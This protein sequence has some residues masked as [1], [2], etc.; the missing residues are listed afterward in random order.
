MTDPNASAGGAALPAT[1]FFD[2]AFERIPAAA[3]WDGS[4]AGPVLLLFDPRA[5]R[6]WVADAAI[7]LATAWT[8]AGRRAVLA[9]LSLD[10]PLLHERIGMANLDGVVDIFL[11]GAS[12]ARSARPVPGRGFYLISG[13]TYTDDPGDILRHP[14]WEKIVSGFREAQA[15]LL[16]FAPAGA[17]GLDALA[18][19][20][21]D[22]ILFGAPTSG[23]AFLAA[24]PAGVAP[25][26][27]LAPPAADPSLHVE[28]HREPVAGHGAAFEDRF[29]EPEPAPT[30]WP[31]TP[32]GAPTP[33]PKA[34][35]HEGFPTFDELMSTPPEA[36]PVP[37][38]AWETATMPSRFG[39]RRRKKKDAE[40]SADAPSSG[41]PS[42][43]P[44]PSQKRLVVLLLLLLVIAA[45]YF[46]WTYHPEML[47]IGGAATAAVA[48]VAAAAKPP[49]AVAERGT[50]LPY[51]VSTVNF[52]SMAPARNAVR[53][54]SAKFPEV[55]FYVVPETNQGRLFYKVLAGL[56]P[57][58]TQAVAVRNRL[59][60]AG[61]ADTAGVLGPSALIQPRPWAFDLGTFDSDSA[62][63]VRVDSL[64]A[65][66]IPGYVV[67]VPFS[68]GA[69]RWR[70]YGGAFADSMAA[71]PML[72]MLSLARINAPFVRRT[73]RAPAAPR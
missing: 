2:P 18:Q 14:R 1:T 31:S 54:K 7:A 52:E 69:D 6:F 48:P 34:P 45:A 4:Y 62:A 42:T 26:A 32:P 49:A 39:G 40:A 58:T 27:W 61:E 37:D 38:P 13:G 47:R 41:D 36:L 63:T 68:D 66:S 33:M 67:P 71:V 55:P 70:V 29:P 43:P 17:A 24:L 56:Y 15:S 3:A 19:W 72:R 46:V 64:A 28:P 16:L 20:A 60:D 30:P 35:A 59:V 22:A 12:L 44:K 25:R 11:Y 8:Q 73:G 5:D 53:A 23:P 51:A 21:G 57:D 9:D 65:Q 10:D 50:A